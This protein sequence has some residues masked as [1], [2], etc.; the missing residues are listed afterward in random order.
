LNFSQR[1]TAKTAFNDCISLDGH[2][3]IFKSSVLHT[4]KSHILYQVCQ[5]AV[6]KLLFALLVPRQVVNKYREQLVYGCNNFV[7]IIRLVAIARL[8]SPTSPIQ[9][10]YNNIVT[11]MFR[12]PCNILV[13]SWLYQTCQN[14]LVTGL[15]C[16]QSCYKLLTACSKLD[17]TTGNK[18]CEHNLSTACEQIRIQVV[19]RS[20]LWKR[21]RFYVCMK[22]VRWI[23]KFKFHSVGHAASLE[24][25]SW[26]RMILTNTCLTITFYKLYF[27]PS[28]F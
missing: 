24:V 26:Y 1:N 6:N 21:V 10:W 13:I 22:M 14:D 8:F 16:H 27:F 17:T 25:S 9:S 23:L 20:D 4:Q 19:C 5:K 2:K 28:N 15:I 12:Q 18:Q 11:T 7:D 3:G